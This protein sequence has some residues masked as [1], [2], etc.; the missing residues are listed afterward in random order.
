MPR[1]GQVLGTTAI[2]NNGPPQQR[3][4]IVFLGDGFQAGE[5][6][7]RYAPTI[8]RAANALLGTPP[9]DRLRSG[10]NVFRVDVASTDMGASDPAGCGGDG[11]TPRTF[12]DARFCAHSSIRRALAVDNGVA[13]D[14]ARSAVPQAHVVLVLVNSPVW[15]GM[16]GSVGTFSMADGSEG[17]L[18][19]EL[20]HTG[21]G[22]GDEYDYLRG[23]ACG[24]GQEPGQNVHG[25]T[26]FD[27]VEPNLTVHEDRGSLDAHKW[28]RFVPPG[29]IPMLPN[30]DCSRCNPAANP[31]SDDTVGLFA[32]AHYAHCDAY[33]PQ[34]RCMM[35]YTADPFCRVCRDQIARRLGRYLPTVVIQEIALMARHS[36]KAADVSGF[37]M[38]NRAPVIQFDLHA[39]PNQ[40]WRLEDVGGGAI[41]IV[42]VHSGKVLDVLGFSRANG[43]RIIQFDWH[44][45][46]NQKWRVEDVGGGFKRI[47]SVHSGKVLEVSGASSANG[48]PLTQWDYH[49]GWNQ[50]WRIAGV[51]SRV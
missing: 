4:N 42:S 41:R 24:P 37:S 44:G 47:V 49:A 17:V 48:A 38:E 18:I 13:W 6:Q 46:D 22:L 3:W 30:R 39:G 26:F 21:F 35:R 25:F 34:Y 32:G 19:H 14:V 27:L 45:G 23:D 1:N 51:A 31:F 20:G 11:R 50:H 15:G 9:F 5:L 7:T 10:I 8:Q 29:D 40:R 28:G 43:A 16:G 33:R 12:F 2:V 36:N